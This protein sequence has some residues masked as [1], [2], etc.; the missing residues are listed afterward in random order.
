MMV[1]ELQLWEYPPV[2]NEEIYS[3]R[4]RFNAREFISDYYLCRKDK[5]YFTIEE[6]TYLTLQGIKIR[7][8]LYG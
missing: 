3:L 2:Y 4:F 5:E 7:N 1:V 6:A 8:Y